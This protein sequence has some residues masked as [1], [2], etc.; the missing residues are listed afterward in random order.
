MNGILWWTKQIAVAV[1]SVL[2]LIKGIHVLVGAYQLDNPFEFIMYFFSSCL[3]ILVSAS[4]LLYPA[5]RIYGRIRGEKQ[6][7]GHAGESS[8]E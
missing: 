7:Q 6:E 2:F 5:F 8:H 3:L 1:I 4:I